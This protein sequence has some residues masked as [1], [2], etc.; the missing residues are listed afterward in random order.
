MSII[1]LFW[2]LDVTDNTKYLIIFGIIV[3]VLIT[4]IMNGKK[5]VH[6][7][8]K[9]KHEQLTK[10]QS[11]YLKCIKNNMVNNTENFCYPCFNNGNEPDFFYDSQTNQWITPNS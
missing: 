2:Y 4:C 11:N 8:T 10:C 3:C 7:K 6:K 5:K 1:E 9:K